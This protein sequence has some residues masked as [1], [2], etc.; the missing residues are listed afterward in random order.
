MVISLFYTNCFQTLFLCIK[1]YISVIY[2]VVE[3]DFTIRGLYIW[4]CLPEICFSHNINGHVK[5]SFENDHGN[6]SNFIEVV[7]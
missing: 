3:Y 4:Y 7:L 6:A 5:Q 1:K 2:Y